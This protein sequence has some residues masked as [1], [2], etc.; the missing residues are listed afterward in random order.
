MV[1]AELRILFE[2]EKQISHRDIDS[3]GVLTECRAEL[4]GWCFGPVAPDACSCE[5]ENENANAN[6][7]T[8]PNHSAEPGG[9]GGGENRR[10]TSRASYPFSLFLGSSRGSARYTKTVPITLEERRKKQTHRVTQNQREIIGS[11]TVNQI[12]SQP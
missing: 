11:V 5:N 10:R 8:K 12:R 4:A 2:F 9:G 3:R 1:V 6:A 7:I